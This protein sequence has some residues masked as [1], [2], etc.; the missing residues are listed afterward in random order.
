MLLGDKQSLLPSEMAGV[1][2]LVFLRTLSQ[3]VPN[4]V[5]ARNSN[6]DISF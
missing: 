2:C 1:F 5:S 3:F 6:A 4:P